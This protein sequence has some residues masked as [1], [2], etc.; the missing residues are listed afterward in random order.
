MGKFSKKI[1]LICSLGAVLLG[2]TIS[3][4]EP[5]LLPVFRTALDGTLFAPQ[6]QTTP[7]HELTKNHKVVLGLV[8]WFPMEVK[9]I[10]GVCGDGTTAYWELR[11]NGDTRHYNANSKILPT[12]KVEWVYVTE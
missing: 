7:L 1:L 3:Y 12:D 11:V 6:T 8:C 10:D 2:A 4:A 5:V 9:C